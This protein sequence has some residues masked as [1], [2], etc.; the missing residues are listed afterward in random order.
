MI[1][2]SL[3]FSSFFPSSNSACVG[4]RIFLSPSCVSCVVLLK[5]L[6]IEYHQFSQLMQ[7]HG[8]TGLSGSKLLLLGDGQSVDAEVVT[9]ASNNEESPAEVHDT[10]ENQV[11][12][13]VHEFELGTDWR[14]S[15]AR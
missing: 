6:C 4:H 13:Q 2:V 1:P 10:G 5:P 15:K 7:L 9:N 14:K 3:V 11:S 8:V 12:P